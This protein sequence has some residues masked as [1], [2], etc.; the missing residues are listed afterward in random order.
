MVGV[1]FFGNFD[2]ALIAL[3]ALLGLLRRPDLLSADREHARRLSARNRGRR[4]RPEPGSVPGAA[5]EDLHAARR[6]R[7]SDR[8]ERRARGPRSGAWRGRRYRKASRMRRPATR[9]LTASAPPPGRRAATSRNST[10]TATTR[11]SRCRPQAVSASRPGATRAGCRCRPATITMSGRIS[12]MW[13]DAPEQTGALPRSHARLRRQAA[14]PDADGQD[15]IGSREGR[16]APV[17]SV[18]IGSRRRAR[19]PK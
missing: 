1:T 2:L 9:C 12:D 8:A 6:S 19:P 18:R 16:L 15:Q 11:S 17:G 13:V 5:A 7:R 14:D 4:P 3:Y 10:A